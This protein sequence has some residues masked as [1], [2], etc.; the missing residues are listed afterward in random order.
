MTTKY[1]CEMCDEWFSKGG[2]CKQC[3]AAL[4]TAHQEPDRDAWDELYERQ[5]ARDRCDGFE[6]T[7]GKDWT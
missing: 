7:G 6:R 4:Q 5:A 2:D 1:Y 3:G